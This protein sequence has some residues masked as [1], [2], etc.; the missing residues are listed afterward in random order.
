MIFSYSYV[1]F[2][3][4][5]YC[6]F[7]YPKIRQGFSS[8]SMLLL[9][10]VNIT[11]FHFLKSSYNDP[12]FLNMIWSPCIIPYTFKSQGSI[13]TLNLPSGPDAASLDFLVSGLLAL[14]DIPLLDSRPWLDIMACFLLNHHHSCK[15]IYIYV[16]INTHPLYQ[17]VLSVLWV[18]YSA[19]H[20]FQW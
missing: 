2:P 6:L 9:W 10:I 14:A 20:T 1:H 12:Q 15:Y 7:L 16:N 17:L 13:Q 11:L 5:S 19:Y 8:T 3:S 18:Y 4:N